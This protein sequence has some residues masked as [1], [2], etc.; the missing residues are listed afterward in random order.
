MGDKSMKGAMQGEERGA[1]SGNWGGRKGYKGKHS[2]A[3]DI[4]VV[5]KHE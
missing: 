2:I 5:L 3:V 4:R 1:I